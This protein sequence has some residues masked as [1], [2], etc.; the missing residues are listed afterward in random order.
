MKSQLV[1][2]VFTFLII[3]LALTAVVL[4]Y[5]IYKKRLAP[6]P[7]SSPAQANLPVEKRDLAETSLEEQERLVLNPPA[8]DAPREEKERHFKI[9]QN[10]A[11]VAPYLDITECETPKPLVFKV[12]YGE[13]F[14]VKNNDSGERTITIGAGQTFSIPPDGTKDIL[15][16]FDKGP[17]V[18]GYGCDYS[19]REVGLILVVQ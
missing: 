13:K 5:A 12:K 3:T 11:Q 7:E 6:S 1:E 4:G 9:A 10:I 18:Y 19:A 17:G 14:T 16:V 2:R 8:Q 15:P